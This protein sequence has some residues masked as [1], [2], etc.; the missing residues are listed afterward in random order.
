MIIAGPCSA[1]SREQL[2]STARELSQGG[3]GVDVLRAGVWKPRTRP[4]GFEGVGEVGL[5]WLREAGEEFNLRVATEVGLAKHVESALKEGIDMVWLGARTVSNPFAV[6]EIAEALHGTKLQVMIKNPMSC[7]IALWAGAV[8]RIC[9]SL[10]DECY[11]WLIHRGFSLYNSQPY[12]NAPMWHVALEM[13]RQFAALPMLCDPSHIAGRRDLVGGVAQ[14]AA[15]LGYDGLM[16]EA[17]SDPNSAM[18]DAEQQLTP[19][20]LNATLQNLNWRETQSLN[21]KFAEKLKLLRAQIDQYDSELF[22]LLARRMEVSKSIGELKKENNVAI[23][24]DERWRALTERII[25][26]C[27]D[28]KLS[29]EFVL[30]VLGAIHVE[31]IAHQ[32]SSLT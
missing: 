8:E 24:Q 5:Q 23:V 32:S 12:R 2:F 1:E 3:G 25:A 21:D 9:H 10:K 18:S 31:S 4:G 14:V 15:E 28:L 22:E 13:R 6:Q 20:E 30:A 26:R 7:D 17:H 29:Q 19:M 11:V 27:E 16:V